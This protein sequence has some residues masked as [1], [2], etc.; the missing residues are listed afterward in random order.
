MNDISVQIFGGIGYVRRLTNI[1][2][3]W[4]NDVDI[5]SPNDGIRSHN[6][7]RE[8]EPHDHGENGDISCSPMPGQRDQD[9]ES[10]EESTDGKLDMLH[11]QDYAKLRC[12]ET[13]NFIDI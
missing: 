13:V 5:S 1:T 4:D 12:I 2:P 8:K 9:E 7:V 3:Y 10:S 11:F 6:E